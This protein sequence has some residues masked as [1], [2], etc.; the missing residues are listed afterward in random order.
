VVWGS[1]RP[2]RGCGRTVTCPCLG[3]LTHH[4]TAVPISV[5][6]F[7]DPMDQSISHGGRPSVCVGLWSSL[8]Y[9]LPETFQVSEEE[10]EVTWRSRYNCRLFFPWRALGS[11]THVADG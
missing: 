4:N 5:C 8:Q 7:Q 3:V 6:S 10:S 2:D 9:L 11:V 1:R